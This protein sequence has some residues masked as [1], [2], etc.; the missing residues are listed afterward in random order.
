MYFRAL[1]CG[2]S[3]PWKRR[4]SATDGR[5]GTRAVPRWTTLINASVGVEISFHRNAFRA[6]ASARYYDRVAPFRQS[7]AAPLDVYVVSQQR[8]R[9]RR[10]FDE[11]ALSPFCKVLFEMLEAAIAIGAREVVDSRVL[12][13]SAPF[14]P[15]A[16]VV[17]DDSKPRHVSHLLLFLFRRSGARESQARGRVEIRPRFHSGFGRYLFD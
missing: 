5:S 9:Q 4:A 8:T 15:S 7:Y 17:G 2:S 6:S 3:Q 12:D 11:H 16:A 14:A 1:Q 13:N 10:L